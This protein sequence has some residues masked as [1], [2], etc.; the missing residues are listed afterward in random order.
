MQD[1][2][3]EL[4]KREAERQDSSKGYFVKCTIKLKA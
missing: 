3:R 4:L 1:K 2:I